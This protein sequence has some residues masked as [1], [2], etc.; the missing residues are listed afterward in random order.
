M[1]ASALASPFLND[2]FLAEP[3]AKLRLSGRLP[4]AF[5]L[6]NLASPVFDIED[7]C[8]GSMLRNS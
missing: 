6:T 1:A 4:S 7:S 2:I 3:Y 5:S 8:A